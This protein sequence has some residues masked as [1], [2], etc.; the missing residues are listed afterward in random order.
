MTSF[1]KLEKPL[2]ELA[3]LAGARTDYALYLAIF[4]LVVALAAVFTGNVVIFLIVVVFGAI[5]VVLVAA[6][7]VREQN[8]DRQRLV[9]NSTKS[10]VVPDTLRIEQSLSPDQRADIHSIL[11]KVVLDTAKKLKLSTARVRANVFGLD[12]HNHLHIVDDFTYNM[13]GRPEELTIEMPVGE[14]S[15]GRAF[16]S[17]KP[18][19]ALLKDDWAENVLADDELA[20]VH[21]ELRWIIS[22]PVKDAQRA[23]WVLNVDG[24]DDG[25]TVDQLREVVQML[26]RPAHL[27]FTQIADSIA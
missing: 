10:S 24:L 15:S 22:M 26:Y 23:V 9:H 11:Q 18:N 4:M 5:I 25:P 27:M 3:K 16:Q 2:L 7:G 14:G 12:E 6:L 20:K 17:G 8:L 1:P 21:P 19:I 13:T